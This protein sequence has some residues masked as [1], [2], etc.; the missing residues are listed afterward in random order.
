LTEVKA[1]GFAVSVKTSRF[2]ARVGRTVTPPKRF[3][4]TVDRIPF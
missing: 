2:A 4:P 3:T 1:P